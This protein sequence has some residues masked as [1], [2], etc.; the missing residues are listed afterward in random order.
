MNGEYKLNSAEAEQ[1]RVWQIFYENENKWKQSLKSWIIHVYFGWMHSW[2]AVAALHVGVNYTINGEQKYKRIKEW[3]NEYMHNE[4]R[5][6]TSMV[7]I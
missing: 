6:V 3:M 5:G 1:N 2:I 4:N 7:R